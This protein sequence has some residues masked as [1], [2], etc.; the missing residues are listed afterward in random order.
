MQTVPALVTI[1][2]FSAYV[3]LGNDLTAA[4]AFTSLS[5]F[6]V[7]RMPLFQMPMVVGQAIS[8]RVALGRLKVR[9]FC[10]RI[11][12]P[13]HCCLLSVPRALSCRILQTRGRTHVAQGCQPHAAPAGE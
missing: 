5:L 4:K 9:R 6:E 10:A 12:P 2:T 8:A 13:A 11:L 7:L 3:L 1:T